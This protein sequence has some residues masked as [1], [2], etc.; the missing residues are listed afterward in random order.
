MTTFPWC[1]HSARSTLPDGHIEW[2]IYRRVTLD[3]K[4]AVKRH[5]GMKQHNRVGYS[6]RRKEGNR[7]ILVVA[8]KNVTG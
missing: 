4:K 7:V 2:V 3:R 6:G 5:N 1:F 8:M